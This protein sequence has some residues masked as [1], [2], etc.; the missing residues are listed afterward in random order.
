MGLTAQWLRN[1]TRILRPKLSVVFYNFEVLRGE[2]EKRDFR[3]E[4]KITG[5]ELGS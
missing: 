3:K 1:A 5:L 2:E 4:F